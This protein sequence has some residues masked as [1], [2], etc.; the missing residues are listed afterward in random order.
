MEVATTQ[1][2]IKK[3][4]TN[5]RAHFNVSLLY[6]LMN[7]SFLYKQ[8]INVLSI[9]GANKAWISRQY[10]NRHFRGYSLKGLYKTC[11]AGPSAKNN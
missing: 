11:T 3:E 2:K 10:N 8:P 5:T 7:H 4:E 9:Q 1:E 6:V